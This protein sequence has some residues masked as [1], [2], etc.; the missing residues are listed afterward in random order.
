M[1]QSGLRTSIDLMQMQSFQGPLLF[2][3]KEAVYLSVRVKTH[4]KNAI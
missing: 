4:L 2:A 1:G 3:D